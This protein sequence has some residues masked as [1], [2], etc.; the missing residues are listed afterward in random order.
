MGEI[1]KKFTPTLYEAAYS[2]EEDQEGMR[3]DQFCAEY[4]QSFSRQAIKRKIAKGEVQILGR[5]FPHK[6]SVKVYEREEVRF[7]TPRG[8]LE[9]EFWRGKLLDLE[10]TPEILFEDDHIIVISKPS[11]MT[12][13]PSGKHLF[14]CAT[15]F[16]E[17]KLGHTI[18]SIHRIDRETSGVLALAKNPK[19]AGQVTSLFEKNLVSKCY[20]FISHNRTNQTFPFTADERM[21]SLDDFIPKLFVHCFDQ[22]SQEGKS[23]Q[24]H[25]KC[26]YEND[27][28]ILGLAFPRT[29]RQHQIRAH[30]A[31]YGFPLIGDKLYNGDPKVFMRFKD[32]IATDDDHDLMDISRHALHATGLSFPY[33]KNE[34]KL[35]RAPIPKDLKSWI[36]KNLNEIDSDQL[37]LKISATIKEFFQ[38]V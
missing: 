11:Y 36:E 12:T 8:D 16:F 27:D 14:N 24:T 31:H 4:L 35:F 1:Y 26:L 28:Y 25:F 29:G 9:D 6:P 2:V 15:V 21:G 34:K 7:T 10:F 30:A 38:V 3:L 13:H 18:H 33:P 37:E 20:F 17:N 19:A 22:R 23:A 5:T 32:G